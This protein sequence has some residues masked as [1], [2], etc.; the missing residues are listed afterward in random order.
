MIIVRIEKSKL[1][2]DKLIE[3]VINVEDVFISKWNKIVAKLIPY[4]NKI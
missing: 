2:F 1:E 3:L 4:T